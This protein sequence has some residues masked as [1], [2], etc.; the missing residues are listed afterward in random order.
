MTKDLPGTVY[1][2][3]KD[4]YFGLVDVSF[5]VSFKP[6]ASSSK[7]VYFSTDDTLVYTAFFADF[8]PLNLGLVC[9]FCQ[10]LQEVISSASAVGKA[11]VYHT[12]SP[13]AWSNSAVLVCAYQ[14]FVLGYSAEKAYAPF[15]GAEAFIPFR[16][17]AFCLN[18]WPLFVLGT[19]GSYPTLTSFLVHR[20]PF[21]YFALIYLARGVISY[22]SLTLNLRAIKLNS[23]LR[24]CSSHGQS[25]RV[26]PFQLQV[27]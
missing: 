7:Y 2:L 19:S 13:Q 11:V 20:L 14:I 3:T 22:S 16:D 10:Q 25:G 18:T 12:A 26:R 15:M 17:A 21:H 8:G 4:L 9:T 1:H 6:S 24:L 23:T 27:V 5:D